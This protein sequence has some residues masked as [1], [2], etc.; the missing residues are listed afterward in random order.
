MRR[1][2]FISLFFSNAIIAQGLKSYQQAIPQTRVSFD[3]MAIPTGN[4]PMMNINY[5]L[6]KHVTQNLNLQ[7]KAQMR[8]LDRVRPTLILP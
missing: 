6:K 4:L 5:S 8:S 7:K 2:V 1:L 3:M